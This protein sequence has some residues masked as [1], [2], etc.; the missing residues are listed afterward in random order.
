[1]NEFVKFWM[2][3]YKKPTKASPDMVEHILKNFVE[4]YV[5]FKFFPEAPA[6]KVSQDFL[7][8]LLSGSV[9]ITPN[10]TN[11]GK[12]NGN[13]KDPNMY[14][15][16]CS[17]ADCNSVQPH[18]ALNGESRSDWLKVASNEEFNQLERFYTAS[19]GICPSC[20]DKIMKEL[21]LLD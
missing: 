19:H 2:P 17:Y 11:D 3:P 8:E 13:K 7:Q 21:N 14:L 10:T 5:D 15:S 18:I 16:V 9:Y 20:Y 6:V 12:N 4:D 1:M